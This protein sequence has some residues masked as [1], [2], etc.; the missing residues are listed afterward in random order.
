VARY[1]TDLADVLRAAGEQV[2]E[3][4]GWKTRGR[5]GLFDPKGVL[6]HHTAGAGDGLA[7][8]TAMATKGRPD[9]SPPL[10]QLALSRKGVWYVLAAGRANHAGRCKAIGGLKPY[11]GQTYGDGNE[12]LL[13]I[14]AQNRGT[15]A[16]DWEPTQYDA[17]VRGV[18]AITEHYGWSIIFGHKETSTSGKI[19]PDFPMDAFRRA[20][21]AGSTPRVALRLGD[22]GTDVEALQKALNATGAALT[23]DG[24]YGPDTET[25]VRAFQTANGLEVDGIAGPATQAALKEDDMFTDADRARLE[26]SL[27]RNDGAQLRKDIG[28]ARDQVIAANQTLQATVTSL[29]ATVAGQAA[30]ITALAADSNVDAESIKADVSAAVQSA[31]QGLE[32]TLAVKPGEPAA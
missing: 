24:S 18:R 3:V 23:V 8:A 28:Y 17:Y 16:E 1:L 10:A 13:G 19:D 15:D 29:Q 26:A 7:D 32:V 14:E 31:I 5:P 6:C 25:A 27:T 30:A 4:P 21:A 2:V 20:V 22:R 9:L 11:P 12:Q